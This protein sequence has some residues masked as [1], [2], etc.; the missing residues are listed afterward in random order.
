M[1]RLDVFRCPEVL[2]IDARRPVCALFH[3]LLAANSMDMLVAS[4]V[5]TGV[6]MA[7]MEQPDVV[8]IDAN[9]DQSIAGCHRLHTALDSAHIPVIV[10]ARHPARAQQ[11]QALACGAVDYLAHPLSLHTLLAHL[12]AHLSVAPYL[13]AQSGIPV[14]E[15]LGFAVHHC[16]RSMQMVLAVNAR[17]QSRAWEEEGGALSAD[18]LAQQLDVNPSELV[19]VFQRQVGMGLQEYQQL[20]LL[21]GAR[22][23]LCSSALTP[24]DI[25]ARAGYGSLR[26]L[27]RGFRQRYGMGPRHYQRLRATSD[28]VSHRSRALSEPH[29]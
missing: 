8:L 2:V 26:A 21:D 14:R 22:H 20:L 5:H 7:Q 11:R 29:G 27:I 12:C 3:D 24:A 6:R 18:L 13:R 19:S 23:R 16:N 9:L 25:A 17:V 15:A 4:S 28:T 1:Q 10:W